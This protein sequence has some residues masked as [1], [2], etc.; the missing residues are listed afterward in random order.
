MQEIEAHDLDD[1]AR[2]NLDYHLEGFGHEH[3]EIV[4][5]LNVAKLTIKNRVRPSRERTNGNT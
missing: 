3:F 4:E 1:P 2:T 5:N